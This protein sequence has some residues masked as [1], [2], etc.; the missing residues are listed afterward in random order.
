MSGFKYPDHNDRRSAADV[1]R[2][3]VLE[4]MKSRVIPGHPDFEKLQAERVRLAAEKEE[5][6]RAAQED[7]RRK[8]LE[9]KAAEQAAIVAKQKAER[10]A[11]QAKM[12]AQKDLDTKQKQARDARYAARKAR[13][14]KA[15]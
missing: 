14:K 5:R 15:V 1:A 13:L 3:A 10:S 9:A 6:M 8:E 4:K 7:K 11:Y 2:K 12:A